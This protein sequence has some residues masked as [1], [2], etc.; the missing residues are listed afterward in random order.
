MDAHSLIHQLFHAIP[1]MTSPDGQPVNAV[2]GFIRDVLHILKD[3]KPDYLICAFD[4]KE[5]TF[6]REIYEAYKAQR[7][8]LDA[9]IILQIELIEEF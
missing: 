8:E 5:P 4:S 9:D 3:Y 2:F 1:E 7:P 6:R